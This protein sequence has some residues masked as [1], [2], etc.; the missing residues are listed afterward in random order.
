M[1]KSAVKKH[2]KSRSESLVKSFTD[3]LK[4]IYKKTI[5]KLVN[6]SKKKRSPKKHVKKNSKNNC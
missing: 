4:K 2:R 5:G 1:A 3:G 6:Y